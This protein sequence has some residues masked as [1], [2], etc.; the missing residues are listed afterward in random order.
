MF[1]LAGSIKPGAG[2]TVV[3]HNITRDE[4]EECVNQD[5]FVQYDVVTPEILEISPAKVDH[6]LSFLAA[7]S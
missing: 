6:R 7:D 1:L 2:G 4:L 5:P 3:A